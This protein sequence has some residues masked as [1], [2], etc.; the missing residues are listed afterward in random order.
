[1]KY[2]IILLI[3]FLTGCSSLPSHKRTFTDDGWQIV[4][5]KDKVEVQVYEQISSEQKYVYD[6]KVVNDNK[7]D[8]CVMIGWTL[9]DLQD[10]TVRPPYVIPG[11]SVAF[12]GWFSQDSWSFGELEIAPRPTGYVNQYQVVDYKEGVC[13]F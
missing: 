13:E 3:A 2:P 12:A 7:N 8:K 1:M 10:L 11:K 9:V 5:R 4:A 6:V